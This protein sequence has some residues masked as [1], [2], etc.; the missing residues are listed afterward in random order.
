MQTIK[1]NYKT[2]WIVDD[3]ERFC[4]S[5]KHIFGTKV[6]YQVL[7]VSHT[8]K[9]AYSELATYSPEYSPDLVTVDLSLPDGNGVELIKWLDLHFP[10][11]HKIIVSFWGQENLVF[12]AFIHGVNGYIQ[13][14]HLLNMEIDKALIALEMGG[15]QISPKLAARVLHYFQIP[16]KQDLEKL[17]VAHVNVNSSTGVLPGMG[18]AKYNLT[19]EEVAVLEKMTQGLDYQEAAE[20]LQIVDNNQ[21]SRHI[22][23]IYQKL[24][25]CAKHSTRSSLAQTEQ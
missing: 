3:D 19:G 22:M 12:D 17:E 25:T 14:D 7:G 8:M 13:K 24:N 23:A 16:L 2:V 21:V 1:K 6:N 10:A 9:N 18:S 20:E 15:T 4:H 11:V 5:L